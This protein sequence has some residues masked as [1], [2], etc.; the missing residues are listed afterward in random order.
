MKKYLCI[1]LLFFCIIPDV[2]T[3]ET[4]HS[5]FF[6]SSDITYNKIKNYD[7]IIIKNLNVTYQPGEPQLP[8][9]IIH[10]LIPSGTRVSNVQIIKTE[11]DTLLGNYL[12]YPVQEPVILS[13]TDENIKF[14]EPKAEIYYSPLAFPKTIIKYSGNANSGGNNIAGFFVY[15]MQY[16]PDKQKVIFYSFIQFRISTEPTDKKYITLNNPTKAQQ[17][18]LQKITTS[19]AV[20]SKDVNQISNVRKAAILSEECQYLIITN[21]SYFNNFQPL[22]DWKTKKGV[23]AGIVSVESIKNNYHGIDDAEKIRN[24]IKDYYQNYGTIWVLLGGDTDVVPHRTAFAISCGTSYNP[25]DDEIPC[26]LYFSDLD[27]NWDFNRNGRYGEVADSVD[28]FPEVLV[29]RAAVGTRYEADTFVSKILAYEKPLDIDYQTNVLFA[30]EILWN[31]PYTDSGIGKDM[32]EHEKFPENVFNITK[33]YESLGNES[34]ASVVS[35]I[36]SGQNIINH[37]GHAWHSLMSV[38]SGSLTSLTMEGL[39]NHPKYGI[40]FSIGCWP[41]AFDR[42]CVAEAFLTNPQ[43]GG[44]AFI[45]NSRYGWGSPGNPGYGYSD[46]YDH[47]FYHALF[48]DK[49]SNIGATLSLSKAHFIPYSR[50]ENVYRWCMYQV[51][52]LGDPEMPIWT[53]KPKSISVIHPDSIVIGS[54]II[55]FQVTDNGSP[56]TNAVV[57]IRQSFDLYQYAC[58]G[59]NGEINFPVTI[60]NASEPILVT[61]T[62]ENFQRWEGSINVISNAAYVKHNNVTLD[63]SAGNNDGFLNPAETVKLYLSF[64]NY[65]NQPVSD[66]EACLISQDSSIV[67]NDSL[68]LIGD[69]AAGDSITCTDSFELTTADNC[70]NGDVFYQVLKIRSAIGDGWDDVITLSIA[71]PVI[72]FAKLQVNDLQEGNVN[73]NFPEAGENIS[74]YIFLKN[75]GLAPATNVIAT[76]AS[77]DPY[78]ILPYKAGMF[79]DLQTKETGIDSFDIMIADSCPH[80]HFPLITMDISTDDGYFFNE[81]FILSIGELGFEDDLEQETG[82]WDFLP[83]INEWHLTTYRA[84]SQSHSWYCGNEET[85]KYK[86]G[87]KVELITPSFY[88]GPDYQLS[89]WTWYDVPIYRRYGYSGDGFYVE[90]FNESFSKTLD[91]IGSGGDLDST[92]MGHDWAEYSYDLSDIQT[93]VPLK[94]KFTFHSDPAEELEG[95]YLDDIKVTSKRATSITENN[96]QISILPDKFFLGQNYP[97]PFNQSTLI[98][99]HISGTGMQQVQLSVYNILGQKIKTIVNEKQTAGRYTA[100]WNGLDKRDNSVSSGVYIYHLQ[101]GNLKSVKKLVILR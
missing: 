42:D 49:I 89:F 56:V 8:L 14:T 91:W 58:T 31:D 69:L 17:N 30:A 74:L 20:N 83:P 84:H 71:T 47:Q 38:G 15:P 2:Y 81:S 9:H 80:V 51:N 22:V 66:L 33:L 63:D 95:V 45:G 23:P 25:V 59:L 62:A 41:A 70:L 88:I 77:D 79:G 10:F 50:Q 32:I 37:D 26:D 44:V 76:M 1:L 13:K 27:G 73:N 78:L 7:A 97:N 87:C 67:V 61:V 72:T 6:Q 53:A 52:L 39:R 101:I 24:C 99:Y 94:V 90:I 3:W 16:L 82:E 100:V 18:H 21:K 57:C 92:L 68:M 55:S 98:E 96:Q 34:E 85:K 65:G 36:N 11:S 19:L 93:G 48:Q 4:T 46:R 40:L 43:G 12:L 60:S 75:S 54:S 5:V 64:K 35:K 86:P 28:L 29:G